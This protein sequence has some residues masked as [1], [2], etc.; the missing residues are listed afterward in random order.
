MQYMANK[1]LGAFAFAVSIEVSY[2]FKYALY[3]GSQPALPTRADRD[4]ISSKA[5]VSQSEILHV[6]ARCSNLCRY[7]IFRERTAALHPFANSTGGADEQAHTERY[8]PSRRN[9]IDGV[10]SD[11]DTFSS[12]VIIWCAERQDESCGR[13]A[14]EKDCR[15][16]FWVLIHSLQA[17]MC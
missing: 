15:P 2:S 3:Q 14:F 13:T 4:L 12:K 1:T 16:A 6:V 10:Q 11:L 5:F 17:G 7:G 9:H 8:R